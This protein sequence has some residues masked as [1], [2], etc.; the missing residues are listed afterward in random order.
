VLKTPSQHL[1][2]RAAGESSF[3]DFGILHLKKSANPC[4]RSRAALVIW[5]QFALRVQSNLIEHSPKENNAPDL[6][7]GM[8]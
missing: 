4:V 7:C 1:F 6:L 3:D 2:V 5:R 8:S